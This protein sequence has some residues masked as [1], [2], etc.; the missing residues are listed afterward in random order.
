VLLACNGF[1]AD[2]DA[3]RQ[4]I[5]EIA[6]AVYHGSEGSTG[7]AIELGRQVGADVRQL[8]AY[9]GH[10][11]LAMPAATL[12][13]WATVMHGG[14]LV[15]AKGRRFGDET[16]G[17]SEYASTVLE[18]ANG[19][20]WIVIDRRIHEACMAFTDYQDTVST[21]AVKWAATPEDLAALVGI[22]PA[23]LADTVRGAADLARGQDDDEFGRTHWGR[24][25]TGELGAVAVSPALFHTQG[26]LR[27][28]RDARVLR[29]D[30]SP[31]PGLYA[32]G[33]S[34][35][36]LS[37]SGATGYL[38]GNGLRSAFGLA[39]LAAEHAARGT[40]SVRDPRR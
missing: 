24:P 12:V 30:G 23:G 28:D 10:A 31:I 15:D 34:A 21:G 14:Y 33:G 2:A 37:G 3:V 18:R 13:G 4:H 32:S 7:D 39:V 9:Q 19:R 27:V 20:A 8:D 40:N 16:V 35:V 1:G 38:A 6:D 22:D 29:P 36:G 26:G 25:L 17:Y 11:A 5:A